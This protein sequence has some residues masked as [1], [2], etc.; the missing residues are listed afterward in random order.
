MGEEEKSRRVE[1]RE[2]FGCCVGDGGG[3]AA[4]RCLCFSKTD[5]NKAGKKMV[6]PTVKCLHAVL[7]QFVLRKIT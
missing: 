2:F 3:V 4:T 6:S 5:S 7:E 1:W